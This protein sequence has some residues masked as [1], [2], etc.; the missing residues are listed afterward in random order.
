MQQLETLRSLDAVDWNETKTEYRVTAYTRQRVLTTADQIFRMAIPQGDDAI[1]PELLE[2]CLDRPRFLPEIKAALVPPATEKAVDDL[3]SLM[4]QVRVLGHRRTGQG[5]LYFNSYV[6]SDKADNIARAMN[7]FKD[8]Q[9][10]Q[11]DDLIEAVKA[12]P[13]LDRSAAKVSPEIV[14]MAVGLGLVETNLVASADGKPA[15]FLTLPL[16]SAPSTGSQTEHLEDDTFHHAKLLL[17]SLRYGEHMSPASR[18]RIKDPT[19]I[20]NALLQRDSVGPC[21][22]IGQDYVLLEQEGVIRATRAED[23]FGNQYRMSIRRREPAQMVLNV[24]VG[25]GGSAQADRLVEKYSLPSSYTS[26]DRSRARG[27]DEVDERTRRQ[28]LEALRS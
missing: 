28:F 4:V 8:G 21:T 19:W 10:Q 22:A 7:A 12:R 23:R 9:K 17:S 5:D 3:L 20:V 1:L 24:L 11:L 25:G 27:W 26:P 13:G 15:E 2:F 18:G 16:L 6:F 14:S